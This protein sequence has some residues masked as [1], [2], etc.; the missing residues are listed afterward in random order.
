MS[1][2]CECFV[3]LGRDLCDGTVN[4]REENVCVCVRARARVFE[5]V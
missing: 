4:G 1:I 3:L 5:C 2:C